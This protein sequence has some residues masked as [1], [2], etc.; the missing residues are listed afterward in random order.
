[1]KTN[2]PRERPRVTQVTAAVEGREVWRRRGLP[3]LALW[4]FALLAY[5][6][7]FRTGFALDNAAVIQH[8]LI[9]Q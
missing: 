9:E 7:S 8:I 6:N 5:S 2:R 1:M 3:I 4:T